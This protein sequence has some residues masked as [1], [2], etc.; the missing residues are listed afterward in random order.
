M[1][2]Y[3]DQFVAGP[4]LIESA[5]KSQGLTLFQYYNRIS[6]TVKVFV[7]KNTIQT[8]WTN[9]GIFTW[10]NWQKLPADHHYKMQ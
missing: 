4:T 2:I 10:D 7:K 1:E 5:G 3:D 6:K 9:L 8:I